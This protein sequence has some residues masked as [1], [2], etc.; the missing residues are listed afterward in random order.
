DWNDASKLRF[1]K[2]TAK[3][4]LIYDDGQ[5]DVPIEGEVSFWVVPWRMLIALLVVTLFFFIG[6]R[7]TVRDI[8]NK[9]FRKSRTAV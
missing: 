3:L 4:L 9:I 1:G 8:W 2:Y 5:R 6:I 7:S